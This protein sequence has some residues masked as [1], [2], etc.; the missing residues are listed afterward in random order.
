M[1]TMSTA[2]VAAGAQ[3]VEVDAADSG[4]ADL[5]HERELVE[6]AVR[7]VACIEAVQVL[8][9]GVSRLWRLWMRAVS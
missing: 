5:G 2:S 9:I 4:G 6:G 7:S 8:G 1:A 3:L